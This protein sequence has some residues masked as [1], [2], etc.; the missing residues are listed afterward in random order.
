MLDKLQ[1]LYLI[2]QHSLKVNN[3]GKKMIDGATNIEYKLKKN[4]ARQY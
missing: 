4:K 2:L 3:S 1:Y